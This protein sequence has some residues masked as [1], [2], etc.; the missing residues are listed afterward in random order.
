MSDDFESKV[1]ITADVDTKQLDELLKTLTQLS[2][3]LNTIGQLG[4]KQGNSQAAGMRSATMAAKN[5][6]AALAQVQRAQN[7]AAQ[8]AIQAQR[9]QMRVQAQAHQQAQA[10]AK[11]QAQAAAQAAR[12]Q[13]QAQAAANRA[14]QQAARQQAQQQ[15][16]QARAQ[17][18][19]QS[20]AQ[21]A[22]RNAYIGQAFARG[23]GVSAL[24][25]GATAPTGPMI[26]AQLAGSVIRGT[27]GT[28]YDMATGMYGATA[29]GV[30]GLASAVGRLPGVGS[31]GATAVSAAMQQAEGGLEF[32]RGVSQLMGYGMAGDYQA[33]PERLAK[34]RRL[35]DA[36]GAGHAAAP[37]AVANMARG[38]VRGAAD[39]APGPL[40][41]VGM[42]AK[43]LVSP[44]TG[45]D[46]AVT[47]GAAGGR[48]KEQATAGYM[49]F[50][51]ELMKSLG[52]AA[53]AVGD[54]SA[55]RALDLLQQA[56]GRAGMRV[57]Q[58]STDITTGGGGGGLTAGGQRLL[59][60]VTRA[61][62]IGV[63]A[64][65]V[66]SLERLRA[67][68]TLRMDGTQGDST[69]GRLYQQLSGRGLGFEGSEIEAHMEKLVELMESLEGKGFK[70]NSDSMLGMAAMFG[71]RGGGA[72]A[73]VAM[74]SALTTQ[75]FATELAGGGPQDQTGWLTMRLF[76][77]LDPNQRLSGG[78]GGNYQ[79]GLK[80]IAQGETFKD[81]ARWQKAMQLLG[82]QGGYFEQA[83][84][85]SRLTGVT[86][87]ATLQGW[88]TTLESGS[89]PKNLVSKV[90]EK[91]AELPETRT[92]S[93]LLAQDATTED[94]NLRSGLELGQALEDLK[95]AQSNVI[96]AV[97]D[98][99]ELLQTLVG[100][101]NRSSLD[102]A[103]AITDSASEINKV[104]DYVVEEMKRRQN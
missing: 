9:Q 32:R 28:A 49:T 76:G 34:A 11:A 89:I 70:L 77:G 55:K 50:E 81:P 51:D 86:D 96:K 93:P 46:N 31:Y 82:D 45:V 16:A 26:A 13:A 65:T 42:A 33:S 68:G 36:S 43:A 41:G 2:Q 72:S 4:T 3:K 95:K 52:N 40:T 6:A 21:A 74:S 98:S 61:T 14:Q 5:L 102:I 88:V 99:G 58:A 79:Q 47:G 97:S 19:S 17:Q 100:A 23:V 39:L 22:Q 104:R 66:G 54:M 12:L 83:G 62:Q 87:P 101:I 38:V 48:R 10:Q 75:R 73:R 29:Q 1:K 78:K 20:Q 25:F 103:N 35:G 94:R 30:G 64:G 8:T 24:P 90:Q 56:G 44:S 91:Q 85:L 69:T 7:T 92:R 67:S 60:D 27:V 37:S 84:Y 18:Q 63:G 53:R 57:L 59:T 15:R 71:P 80:T